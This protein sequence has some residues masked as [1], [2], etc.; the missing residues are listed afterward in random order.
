MKNRSFD[1]LKWPERFCWYSILGQFLLVDGKTFTS[2]I[3]IL[4]LSQFSSKTILPHSRLTFQ[5]DN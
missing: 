3:S 5:T 4:M 1:F 2:K